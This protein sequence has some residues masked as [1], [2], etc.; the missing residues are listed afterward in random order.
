MTLKK[1]R[2]Q[3]QAG[4]DASRLAANRSGS[5]PRSMETNQLPQIPLNHRAN[6]WKINKLMNLNSSK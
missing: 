2:S 6:Y 4:H 3:S 5:H 1:A